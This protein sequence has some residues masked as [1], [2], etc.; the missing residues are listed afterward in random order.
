M[1]CERSTARPLPRWG[2]PK[3]HILERP[4][5]ATGGLHVVVQLLSLL[6]GAVKEGLGDAVHLYISARSIAP[7]VSRL[8]RTASVA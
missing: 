4:D 3:G 5:G 7:S 2:H 6:E 8:P 1:P